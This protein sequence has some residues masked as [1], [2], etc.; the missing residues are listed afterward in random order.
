MKKYFRPLLLLFILSF[1]TSCEPDNSENEEP[2]AEDIIEIPDEHFKHA[3]VSTNSIDTNGDKVGDS[4]I[5]LNNDGEI[6]RSEAE[7]VESLILAFNH[8]EILRFVDL[9]GIENFINLK[10]LKIPGIGGFYGDRNPSSEM[11]TYDFTALKKLEFLETY[12]LA[13]NFFDAFDLSG[14]D[15]LKEVRLIM[16]RPNFY[17]EN[18]RIPENYIEVNFEGCTSLTTLK[19]ENSFL[20]IDF[21]QIPSLK[22]LDM[23]YLEGGEPEVFD[24]HCLTNLE[25][26]DISENSI[27][28][29]I[30]K[31][32][33]V[34]TT[35]RAE[36]I[37]P[38]AE[39]Y[40]IPSPQYICID[41]IPEE[42]E[43]IAIIRDDYTVVATDCEF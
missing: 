23:S 15:R 25:W 30:L 38:L 43:Q 2:E 19:I 36:F 9:S 14:L 28:T 11:I 8:G 10:S 17:P 3:L 4:D 7:A 20:K 40:N 22:I 41:N 32:S 21:C 42:L 35:F 37:G 16:N 39:A 29:L 33:S 1:A 34:L 26:L 27:K 31:N 5:D 24:F 18:F 12:D 13:S 6:Q